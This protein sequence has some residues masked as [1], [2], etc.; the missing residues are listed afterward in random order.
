VI[1]G[2][3][4]RQL[5]ATLSITG[6][7]C[8]LNCFYCGSKYI[9]SMTEAM[10][11]E[12]FEK[13]VRRM[14]RDGARGFLVS[15]GFDAQGRLPLARYLSVMK[16]LKRELGVIFNVHPGLLDRYTITLMRDAVDMVDYE[17]AYT[18]AAFSAKGVRAEREDYIRVLEYLI[19]EGPEYIVPHIITGMPGDSKEDLKEAITLASSLKP[20]LL[21]FLVLV[22]TPGTP[23]FKLSVNFDE[24][25]EDITL[26]SKLMAGKVSLGCMRPYHLKEKLDRAVI[27]R[28]LVDRIANPHHKVQREFRLPMYDACC[29][30]PEK[31]LEGFKIEVD[32]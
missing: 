29:S 14:Y 10:T 26:G 28:N 15:G 32:N 6:G 7:H 18:K 5:F 9:A 16:A 20:Y 24:V 19:E 30:L 4:T 23:S 25:L 22:P 3:T 13:A 12:S 27:E 11:P 17:F 21:N 1:K 8:S 31:Y 2:F